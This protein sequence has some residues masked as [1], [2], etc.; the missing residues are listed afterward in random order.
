MFRVPIG[1]TLA[2]ILAGQIVV[3]ATTPRRGGN[4]E[5]AKIANPYPSTAESIASG[6]RTY[7][8]LCLQCHGPDGKGDGGGAGGGGQPADLTD[9]RW[10]FGASDGEI[11]FVIRD[12]TSADMQGCADQVR[13]AD[14]WHLVNYLRTLSRTSSARSPRR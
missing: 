2:S 13:D 5:A 12:G 4:P 11:F 6:K 9:D 3:P 7:Q 14:I 10:D 8:R 1:I